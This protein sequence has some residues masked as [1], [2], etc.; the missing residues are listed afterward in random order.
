MSRR[1]KREEEKVKGKWLYKFIVV[2]LF[3]ALVFFIL[4]YAPNYV[5]TE[6]ADKTNLVINNSNV[7]TDLK[8]DV[9][10][11]DG[12]IYISMEDISNFFDPYVYY[13]DKYNQIITTSDNQI[14][15]M[16][17][18]ENT[19][20]N[21]GSTV[22]TSGTILQ[23]DGTYYIPFSS[24]KDTYNVEIAYIEATN[25]ITVD[26]KDRKYVV[27]D[28]KKENSVK[29]YPTIFSRT[30]DK[31]E[32]QETVTVVQ[33]DENQNNVVD[34]WVEI[35][36]DT[37][38]LGY[39]KADT[40]INELETRKAIE[41]KKQVQGKISMAWDYYYELSTVPDRTGTTIQGVNV[42]SP[43]FFTLVDEGKGEVSDNAGEDGK[44]YVEWA[45]SNGY[46]VWPSI[47][48]NSYIETTSEIM[49]DYNLRHRL[50]E[51]IVS[52]IMEYDLDGINIDF[53]YMHDEDKDLFSRFIIELE[54]RLR[55]IGKVLSVDV[56]APDG[57][58]EWSLC[59]DRNVIGDVADYIVFMAYDQNGDS[60]S[61]P[62]TNAGYDWVKVNLDKFLG[63]E[64][65]EPEKIILGI[66]F[67]TR[68][69][70][71]Q[72]GEIVEIRRVDMKSLDEIIPESAERVWDDDLKQY[73]VEFVE[74][75][76]T[77]KIWIEDAE[78]IKAKLSLVNEYNLAGAAYWEKDREPDS[79]WQVVSETLDIE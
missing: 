16:V 30:V 64:G 32:E 69:W 8:K 48:N 27:A 45:H 36:T 65:V 73:Y 23:R 71:E 12:I 54:P 56:T 55:E 57:S 60:S 70:E 67:Y 37:G 17:V 41:E 15:S 74:D 18:G 3:V 46:M 9:F 79:I 53:E 40:L 1:A 62:G 52:L 33:N 11:E 38:K 10:I 66:P 29:A 2:A 42:M 21:N 44:A 6:I 35:R 59:F 43:T 34:G 13:D 51:N 31:I 50:I 61:E 47:S 7:T 75:G 78:S 68:V 26:S 49:R 14:T 72:N 5:N 4:K 28:S 22:A 77:N 20:V 24:F 63:Q 19:M 76:I 25:T 58:E 39:V